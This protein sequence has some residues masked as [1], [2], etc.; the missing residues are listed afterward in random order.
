M[1]LLVWLLC[2]NAAAAETD[3]ERM[4]SLQRES[5]QA[6]EKNDCGAV[7]RASQAGLAIAER[8]NDRRQIGRAQRQ[9][10]ICQSRQG[11][12]RVALATYQTGLS[13]AEPE[14]DLVLTGEL[15]R[16]IGVTQ[17]AL[18]DFAAATIADER[19]VDLLRQ[20][21]D[22]R[23]TIRSI[24]NLA[25]DYR[26]TGDLRKTAAMLGEAL[27]IAEAQGW[28][29]ETGALTGA[30][31]TL[32]A[33]QGDLAAAVTYLER[34]LKLREDTGRDINRLVSSYLNLAPVYRATGQSDR[35]LATI[36]KALTLARRLPQAPW[37]GFALINRASLRRESNRES[38]ALI[39]LREALTVFEHF[40][41][42]GDQAQVWAN[43]AWLEVAAGHKAEALHASDRAVDLAL[44]H[45]GPDQEWQAWYARGQAL[46]LAGQK[47]LAASAFESAVLSVEA[48]RRNLA[49]GA[50][51]GQSF[52][53]GRAGPFYEWVAML[54]DQGQ[55][56]VALQ[57]AERAKAQWLLDL[58]R[59]G[60]SRLERVLTPTEVAKSQ[61]LASSMGEL[62]RKSLAAPAAQAPPA[63]AIAAR[64]AWERA[65][66]ENEA[67]Q[68][69][70]YASHPELRIVRSTA[71]PLTL[72]EAGRLLPDASTALLEYTV[73]G[74]DL[75][76][77]VITREATGPPRLSVLRLPGDQGELQQEVE[78]FR[79]AL[80]T[81]DLAYRASAT[82]LYQRLLGPAA[83]LLRGKTALG[84]VPDGPLWGL[85][86]QALIAPDGRHV[87][88]TRTLFYAPSLTVLREQTHLARAQPA[89]RMLA[90]GDPA[91][92]GAAL[93]R[94]PNA[95]REVSELSRL[96][97]ADALSGDQAT[98]S[99][100][101][102]VAGQYRILHLAAHGVLN[103]KDPMYSYLALG[104]KS[105]G[106]DG[107]LE[108]REILD[109]DLHADL[110]ILSACETARGKVINGEG[111]IGMSWA[112]QAAGVPVS[113]VSQWKVDS[114]STTRLMLAFHRSLATHAGGAAAAIQSAARSLLQMPRFAHPYYWAGFVVIGNPRFTDDKALPF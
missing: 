21:G 50:M 46:R 42:Q 3:R 91:F 63:K 68:A 6:L 41:R 15:L 96:Y 112:F 61:A 59:T 33:E 111:L 65:A 74:R 98:E 64:Q 108:A 95:A 55:G 93:L 23:G 56:E 16:G 40:D 70:L 26:R 30:L 103:G 102:A 49:G 82:R 11:Q 92:E 27:K 7:L 66:Q 51:Q 37:L 12:Y 86:F 1:K 80:G 52:L 22:Q 45:P 107:L 4:G 34:E 44:R 84:I 109:L 69:G 113:V 75:F 18:G 101:K 53:E 17:R 14:H 32:F 2:L 60:D 81:R 77:F 97:G 25:V 20:A 31:G 47:D 89:H 90:L 9:I 106:Q 94:L 83:T 57:T 54:A 72:A 8:L 114:E 76:L 19:S 5:E 24:N 78:A 13:A 67:F 29:D 35:A 99:R 10:G 79:L 110:V 73:H 71:T 38:E 88:E 62:R 48:V 100:W 28:V 105:D 39:D 104:R 58:I 43:I 36:E 85:P 87:I